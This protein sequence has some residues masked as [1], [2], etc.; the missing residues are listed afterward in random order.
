MSIEV[1]FEKIRVFF[2]QRKRN[3]VSSF[4]LGPVREGCCKASWWRA[5]VRQDEKTSGKG[6]TRWD[7]VR[8]VDPTSNSKRIGLAE[9]VFWFIKKYS[10]LQWN[11]AF[12]VK[13]NVIYVHRS[14]L[15]KNSSL[16]SSLPT[17]YLFIRQKNFD[18]NMN[19][20]THPNKNT[21]RKS[22]DHELYN[23][24]IKKWNAFTTS[25][26]RDFLQKIWFLHTTVWL[27]A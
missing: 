27:L 4:H 24:I 6:R 12:I 14:R 13:I 26:M 11:H 2:D 17:Q 18:P 3:I 7:D 5:G 10:V 25:S 8:Y 15:W 19:S 16:F 22:I 23:R 20:T 1:A 9:K 21:W